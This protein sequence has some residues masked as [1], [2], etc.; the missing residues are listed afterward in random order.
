MPLG[1]YSAAGLHGCGDEIFEDAVHVEQE[2][3]SVVRADLE[4]EGAGGQD[5]LGQSDGWPIALVESS[6]P[7]RWRDGRGGRLAYAAEP[8]DEAAEAPARCGGKV[9]AAEQAPSGQLEQLVFEDVWGEVVHPHFGRNRE[10]EPSPE[11]VGLPQAPPQ[12]GERIVL[13]DVTR[14]CRCRSRR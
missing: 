13:S 1:L 5:Q 10:A 2:R 9:A 12:C 4:V 7:D 3:N 6:E 8:V 14:T 11:L